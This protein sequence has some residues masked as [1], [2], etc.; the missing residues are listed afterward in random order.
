MSKHK[1]V[2]KLNKR[3]IL[4]EDAKDENETADR[5]MSKIRETNKYNKII[6]SDNY[7]DLMSL[8]KNSICHW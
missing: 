7:K 3:I 8:K 6:I 2:L 1:F 5:H 4:T